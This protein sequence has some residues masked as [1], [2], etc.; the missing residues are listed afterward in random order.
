[1]NINVQN[2]LNISYIFFLLKNKLSN[3]YFI[4]KSCLPNTSNKN[5]IHQ[6]EYAACKLSMIARRKMISRQIGNPVIFCDIYTGIGNVHRAPQFERVFVWAKR[7]SR[8]KEN[9]A[10]HVAG[11]NLASDFPRRHVRHCG[12]LNCGYFYMR[13]ASPSVL[14]FSTILIID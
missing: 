12:E 6:T 5:D 8:K 7:A 14:K 2:F 11:R 3:Y 10:L 9:S 13:H 1:M 4:V